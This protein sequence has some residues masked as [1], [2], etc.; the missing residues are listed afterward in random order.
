M[1]ETEGYAAEKTGRKCSQRYCDL[2]PWPYEQ[3]CRGRP[4]PGLSAR[5]KG[6]AHG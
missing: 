3:L 6:L 4:R 5:I 2:R 1:A